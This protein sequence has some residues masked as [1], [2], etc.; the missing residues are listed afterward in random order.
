MLLFVLAFALGILFVR[1]ASCRFRFLFPKV[2]TSSINFLGVLCTASDTY[3]PII[4]PFS[5]FV[6]QCGCYYFSFPYLWSPLGSSLQKR[7]L[8][9]QTLFE[10]GI[11]AALSF[12]LKCDGFQH[13][14]TEP[15]QLKCLSTACGKT[16]STYVF[17][18]HHGTPNS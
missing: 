7:S 16:Q 2:Y 6:W 4:F 18:P 10:V 13:G 8:S 15:F 5:P 1:L 14:M 9:S 11:M 17:F 3:S 12:V